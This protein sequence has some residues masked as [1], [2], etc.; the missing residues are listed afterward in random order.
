MRSCQSSI[1]AAGERPDLPQRD[2]SYQ[3]PAGSLK[4]GT[5]RLGGALGLLRLEELC[6]ARRTTFCQRGC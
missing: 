1:N 5:F 2:K 4:P 6:S 3:G